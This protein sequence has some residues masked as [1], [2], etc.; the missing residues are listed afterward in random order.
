MMTKRVQIA[1]GMVA[2]GLALVLTV[3]NLKHGN[4]NQDEGWYLYAAKSVAA[5]EMP[6]RDF[7]FTQGPI[8]PLVYGAFYSVVERW[9]VAG[10]RLLTALFG[11]G[12]ALLVAGMA[13][14]EAEK[15]K[16]SMAIAAFLLVGC[17]VYQSY[18]TTIVKTYGLCSF[19]LAA[20]FFMLTFRRYGWGCLLSGIFLALAAGTRVS[21]GMTLPLVG[22]WL[23]LQHRTLSRGWI[24]F[25]VGG[26]LM[27]LAEFVPFFISAAEQTH[28]GLLGYHAGR[29]SGDFMQ[30]AVLKVGF[31]SR[32]VQ[33]YFLFAI[34]TLS[35]L[36][37][38]DR[39][40]QFEMQRLTP[41]L[42]ICGIG[43]SAV[44]FI[45]PFPYD[46]Y[47]VIAF[48]LL[49]S[50]L[51]LSL[52]QSVP[53]SRIGAALVFLFLA[54]AAG[55]FSSSINQDWF[56]RGRDR[57]WWQFKGKSDLVVLR[58]A[59]VFVQ[60]HSPAGSVLLT[61]DTYLAVEAGRSVP[62]GMEMG[63]FCYYPDLPRDQA[64][65]LHLLNREMLL[66]TLRSSD[67]SVAAFSGYGLAIE[68]PAIAAVNAEDAMLFE[69]VL[70]TCFSRELSVP[71][72]G[73]AHTTLEIYKRK[74]AE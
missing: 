20:G 64:E 47:Q 39:K 34:L 40:P 6:Y 70:E 67:A 46:D 19:G 71:F 48:P 24:W 36:L 11:I 31:I 7:A 60:E 13:G 44:H 14:R 57:I 23:L 16:G 66:E 12:S 2:L 30:Q 26:G 45:A 61:Q 35:V 22:I 38:R 62:P 32:F 3:L 8:L 72:F 69:S 42:W 68:S 41:L 1:V 15:N 52:M 43:I 37:I 17:N 51:A 5:G 56:V 53:S 28:F 73:Q 59:A 25:G 58:E 49:G 10:G 74:D 63:A 33:A 27:L 9:G 55:A 65:K 50:A 21:A 54:S 4:L 18:F 29:E